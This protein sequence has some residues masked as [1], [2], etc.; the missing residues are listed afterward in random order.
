MPLPQIAVPKYELKLPSTG[1]SVYYR[2][3]LAQEEKVLM[4]ALE[5]DDE[6][7]MILA[8][9]EVVSACTE[10]Q[11]DLSKVTSFDLE[12][13]FLHMRSKA[14]GEVSHI[15]IRCRHCKER[16]DLDVD[17]T[18][19]HV[20]GITEKEIERTIPISDTIGVTMQYPSVQQILDVETNREVDSSYE[21]EFWKI[22]ASIESVYEGDQIVDMK[23]QSR[24]GIIK[25]MGSIPIKPLEKMR[26]FVNNIPVASV[27]VKF[28]C[29]ACKKENE[30]E[31]TGL[32]TFFV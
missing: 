12:Y 10:H 6:K 16:N 8:V 30:L 3:Y 29:H 28:T 4:M 7:Q 22:V 2:P 15:G 14:V 31:A 17:L 1:K 19:T 9:N 18:Q 21:K 11:I 23:E 27:P 24:E 26:A 5:S 25:F 20:K 13:I 32:A